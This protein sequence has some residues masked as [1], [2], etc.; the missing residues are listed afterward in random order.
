MDQNTWTEEQ[1]LKDLKHLRHNW[2]P[3]QIQLRS[4]IIDVIVKLAEE[5][6]VD[7]LA[8]IHLMRS[9]IDS[10][11]ATIKNLEDELRKS[12][13]TYN[14]RISD[15]ERT[16][17][18]LAQKMRDQEINMHTLVTQMKTN[19]AISTE[20]QKENKRLEEKIQSLV[21][22][23]KMRNQQEVTQR[24]VFVRL[25]Q[26][27]I[28]RE[29]IK[30]EDLKHKVERLTVDVD[31]VRKSNSHLNEENATLKKTIS[32]TKIYYEKELLSLMST[33]YEERKKL[34]E[35]LHFYRASQKT[36]PTESAKQQNVEHKSTKLGADLLMEDLQRDVPFLTTQCR[37]TDD[38]QNIINELLDD[39][40]TD[41]SEVEPVRMSKKR[42]HQSLVCD[43]VL[44]NKPRSRFEVSLLSLA[45]EGLLQNDQ[46]LKYHRSGKTTMGRICTDNFSYCYIVDEQTQKQFSAPSSW[47]NN[48]TILVNAKKINH[49][50]DAPK[51]GRCSGWQNV[52]V[53]TESNNWIKL[54]EL[55]TKYLSKT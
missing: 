40:E 49:E 28:K 37:K 16:N 17:R 44:I 25:S 15:L 39:S 43:N 41:T 19:S 53:K 22:S 32:D 50:D 3:K 33:H 27:E 6:D 54:V 21:A 2:T 46:M 10:K 47:V 34:E 9:E 4:Q 26:E 51:H 13:E 12:S 18:Q 20:Q 1:L 8:R 24:Q 29:Q 23:E 36:Q 42:K 48:S 38:V 5:K 45:Q 14:Q 35:M 52:R 30:T 31:T 11:N 7:T 55:R